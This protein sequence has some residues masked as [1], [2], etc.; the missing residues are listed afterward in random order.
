MNRLAT[1]AIGACVALAWVGPG[2]GGSSLS[3]Q[4]QLSLLMAKNRRLEDDLRKCQ[5]Q[6]AAL[7]A[8]GA[9]PSASAVP[10]VQDPWRAV[11]VR[12]GKYTGALDSSRV[13][14]E[15]RLKIVLEPL[16]ADGDVVKRA[17]SLALE[18]LEPSADEKPPQPFHPWTFERDELAKTWLSGL[19]TYAYVLKLPWPHGRAPAGD[20]LLLRAKFT[21]LSGEVLA[22]ETTVTLTR[23][24]APKPAPAPA[25]QASEPGAAAPR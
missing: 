13:T 11:A 25:K 14:G 23:P 18:A 15:E 24:P 8:A 7:T 21:T 3:H 22:A 19:G 10:A 2:C 16:D 9:K 1:L 6:L 17:G 5:E 4:E 20:K 12:F